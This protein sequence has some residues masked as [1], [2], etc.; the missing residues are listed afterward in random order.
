M[1]PNV[2]FYF[3]CRGSMYLDPEN[4]NPARSFQAGDAVF[5]SGEPQYGTANQCD[6][7][8]KNHLITVYTNPQNPQDL[9]NVASITMPDGSPAIDVI[10]LFGANYASDVSPYLRAHNNNPPTQNPLN[11]GIESALTGNNG[12]AVKFVQDQGTLLLLTVLNGWTKV[13]WSEFTNAQTA[14]DF[15]NYLSNDIVNQYDLDGIDIDDE[16]SSGTPNNDSLAMVTT[17]MKGVMPDKLITKALWSDLPYFSASYNGRTLADNLTYGW[18]MS[19]YEDPNSRLSPYLGVGM[20]KNQLCLGFSAEKKFQS[21]WSEVGTQTKD[22]IGLGYEGAMIFS[23]VD[24]STGNDMLAN[25][26]ANL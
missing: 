14:T 5:F 15:A 22:T 25:I 11:P 1:N 12:Q 24:A 18:E 16:Y 23:F 17:M 26:I 21:Q 7:Y 10:A 9:I 20:N 3:Y 6:A 13:G 4:G 2:T 19:Y 8:Q